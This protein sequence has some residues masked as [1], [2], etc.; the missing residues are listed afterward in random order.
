MENS[1]VYVTAAWNHMHYAG[2]QMSMQII[3]NGLPVQYLTND[4]NYDYDSP[5]TYP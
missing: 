5:R 3:R 1:T 4:H 2:S